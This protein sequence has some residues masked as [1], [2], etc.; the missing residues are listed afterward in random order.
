[1][2]KLITKCK[3]TIAPCIA[4]YKSGSLICNS[5][6]PK[7][8]RMADQ[9][10]T[11]RFAIPLSTSVIISEVFCVNLFNWRYEVILHGGWSLTI[12]EDLWRSLLGISKTLL[13]PKD[14]WKLFVAFWTEFRSLAYI[15]EGFSLFHAL[16]KSIEYNTASSIAENIFGTDLNQMVMTYALNYQVLVLWVNWYYLVVLQI[17]FD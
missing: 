17:S 14:Q 7:K 8:G 10:S 15:D 4:L 3:T 16:S 6:I 13:C 1:M 2:W 11:V 12:L 5:M 9:W